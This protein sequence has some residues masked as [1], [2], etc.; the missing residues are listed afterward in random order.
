MVACDDGQ[1]QK[2]AAHPAE[3][4]HMTECPRRR[5]AQDGHARNRL[6]AA[7]TNAEERS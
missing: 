6:Y 4:E 2:P 7:A 1:P 5:C 3:A